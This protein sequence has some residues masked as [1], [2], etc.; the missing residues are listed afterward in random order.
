MDNETTY[1]MPV[2]FTVGDL[3]RMATNL[4]DEYG[5]EVEL[6]FEHNKIVAVKK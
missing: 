3:Y 1:E 6:R 2:D 4:V 5:T